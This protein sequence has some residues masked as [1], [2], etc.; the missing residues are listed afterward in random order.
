[1][2][3]CKHRASLEKMRTFNI[4]ILSVLLINCKAK[5]AGTIP[6]YMDE[7]ILTTQERTFE[8]N[9]NLTGNMIRFQPSYDCMNDTIAYT[10][11][12][13]IKLASGD[14]VTVYSP[15][16]QQ[17]FEPGAL[18]TVEKSNLDRRLIQQTKREIIEQFPK[19]HPNYPYWECISC[20][21]P[22][23]IGTLKAR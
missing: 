17:P 11:T 5:Y 2:I 12:S 3:V 18:L 6:M 1:M 13:I 16:E 15:C 4:L 9:N 14:T 23:T 8:L 22:N 20:K 10:S 21:Y 19:K 7:F